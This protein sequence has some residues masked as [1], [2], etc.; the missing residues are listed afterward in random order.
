MIKTITKTPL[1]YKSI[2]KTDAG[3]LFQVHPDI[4]SN[5]ITISKPKEE[6]IEF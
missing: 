4:H 5:N 3:V 6:K 2:W 1:K